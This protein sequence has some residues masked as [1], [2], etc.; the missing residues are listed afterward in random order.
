M[1]DNPLT[2][3]GRAV[4]ADWLKGFG[5][6]L[7]VISHSGLAGSLKIDG[8]INAFYM[9]MFFLIS[10]FFLHV[11]KYTIKEYVIK[12]IKGLLIPY[13][14]WGVF[15]FAVWMAMYSLK[16]VDLSETPQTMVIGLVWNNNVHMPIAGALWFV[17]CLFIISILSFIAVKLFGKTIYFVASVIIGCVGLYVSPFLPWSANTALVGNLFFA[18]GYCVS[19]LKMK[20]YASRATIGTEIT[21]M[22]L[23]M[24]VFHFGAFFNGFS[25]IREC[26][27][28]VFPVLFFFVALLGIVSWWLVADLLYQIKGMHILNHPIAWVGKYSMPYLCLN[29]LILAV[30]IRLLP[31]TIVG[32]VV[33]T[34]F[35]LAFIS[36]LII[37]IRKIEKK[38]KTPVY[39]VLFG[40]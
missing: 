28:G 26:N 12:K 32:Q 23:L 40:R 19:L 2:K 7:M 17:S 16:I 11:E 25:N 10:G 35:T 13:L 14:I 39:S 20:R 22:V 6:L 36:I 31:K 24:V 21:A 38:C 37:C 27:Y 4:Q 1:H 33:A 29:Q 18:V 5:I 3:Q 15:H 8:Y 9:P 30:L 34:F